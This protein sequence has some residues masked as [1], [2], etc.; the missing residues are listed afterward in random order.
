MTKIRKIKLKAGGLKGADITTIVP[1]EKDGVTMYNPRIDELSRTIPLSLEKCF[2]DLREHA[3]EI[4]GL[5][6]PKM[7]D[8]ERKSAI[9]ETFVTVFCIEDDG[10]R[11]SA[12]KEIFGEKKL[13]LNPPTISMDDGYEG[14]DGVMEIWERMKEEAGLYLSGQVVVS[15]DEVVRRL[16]AAGRVK[17]TTEADFDALT[18]EERKL[19]CQEIL[20]KEFGALVMMPEDVD[21]SGI[22]VEEGEDKSS[23][24]GGDSIVIP[25]E[26]KEIVLPQTGTND[27]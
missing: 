11:L 12:W 19:K 15:D 20:E 8:V 27:F 13:N 9:N 16:I 3:L 10:F 22:D 25:K 24:V 6:H 2:K 14:Y 26:A 7:G 5:L 1:H 18:D 17:K 23:F 4:C 21:T